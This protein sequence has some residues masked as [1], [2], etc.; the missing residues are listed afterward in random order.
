MSSGISLI[1]VRLTIILIEM[2][3]GKIIKSVLFYV[4]YATEIY[5]YTEV[6]KKVTKPTSEKKRVRLQKSLEF[7]TNLSQRVNNFIGTNYS[8][9]KQ[10][11]K[12]KIRK[13][14][15]SSLHSVNCSF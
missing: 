4:I 5:S 6:K 12:C 10:G 13:S 9:T 3:M 1:P 14:P 7:A 11:Q 2:I 15:L 8:L